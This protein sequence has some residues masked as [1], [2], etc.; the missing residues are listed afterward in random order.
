[1]FHLRHPISILLLLL[2]LPLGTGALEYL[3]NLQH[4][5]EDADEAAALIKS[6]KPEKTAPIHDESNCSI[7]AKLH[8][9]TTSTA[10]VP[11]LVFFGLIIAFLT[12]IAPPLI[13]QR[14]FIC[15]V[16]RGP[17]SLN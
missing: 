7:H 5:R 16:C 15:L 12:E 4:A 1:M 13:S 9:L 6:G 2:F 17:P 11:L 8:L 14:Q 10:C 3:H